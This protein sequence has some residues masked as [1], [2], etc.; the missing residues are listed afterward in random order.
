FWQRIGFYPRKTRVRLQGSRPIWIHAAS[1]GEILSAGRL[2]AALKEKFPERKILLSTS[3]STGNRIARQTGRESEAVIFLPFDHPWIVRRALNLFDPSL[4]IFLEKELWPGLLRA[5]YRRGVPTFL[6]SGRLSQGSFRRYSFWRCFFSTVVGQLT[7]VG[8]QSDE[9]AERMVRL[10]VD[11]R[12]VWTTGNLK[13]APLNGNGAKGQG[14]EATTVLPGIEKERQVWVVGSTHR[15][16]EEL[17]LDVFALLKASFPA[18]LMV[19]APRHPHRFVEVEKLLQK[20]AVRYR[21]RSEMNGRGA[22]PPDVIFLDTIGELPAFYSLADVAFVGGSLVDAGGHNLMEPARWRKPIL[23]GPHMTNFAVIAAEMKAR[24]G[25]VE[26]KE[27]ADLVRTLSDLLADRAKAER[28]GELAYLV[29][30]GDRGVV[31]R[32]MGLVSRYLA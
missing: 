21:K 3:T 23:F 32:S 20:R 15:G 17:L 30:E 6:I 16:E 18:L 28:M 22:E 7:A 29:V 5:A 2:V 26:V 25:G 8:M 13:H 9:D 19:L 14:T 24:G 12:R 11:R 1:V 27:K 4:L 10:G 31:E